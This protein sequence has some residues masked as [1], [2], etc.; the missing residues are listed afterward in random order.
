MCPTGALTLEIRETVPY[1]HDAVEEHV[2]ETT[3]AAVAAGAPVYIPQHCFICG[4]SE[5]DGPL[6]PVRTKGT[7]TWVC[8][9]CLPQLDPRVDSIAPT[10]TALPRCRMPRCPC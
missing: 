9:R 6:L 1:S 10:R 2:A 7:S 3:A 5:D 8:T 4:R